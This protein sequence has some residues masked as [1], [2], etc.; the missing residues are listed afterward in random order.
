[1]DKLILKHL[2]NKIY[3]EMLI[4]NL[5]PIL[6]KLSKKCRN[7]RNI[8]KM[9]KLLLF[10]YRVVLNILVL[11]NKKIK[12]NLINMIN[13]LEKKQLL[14]VI[15]ILPYLGHSISWNIIKQI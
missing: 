10:N 2:R 3:Q 14:K 13:F 4:L 6:V 5:C 1:M 9:L 7:V 15:I 12:L 8:L 11:R